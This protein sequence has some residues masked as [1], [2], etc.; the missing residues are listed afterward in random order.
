MPTEIGLWVRR[1]VEA[2]KTNPRHSEMFITLGSVCVFSLEKNVAG[3][4]AQ[5]WKSHFVLCSSEMCLRSINIGCKNCPNTEVPQHSRFS[6]PFLVV[7]FLQKTTFFFS[8]FPDET[9]YNR[10]V[11]WTAKVCTQWNSFFCILL[12]F[13][14]ITGKLCLVLWYMY[15][16]TV[17]GP[18]YFQQLELGCCQSWK[19]QQGGDT[20][21][22]H[23]AVLPWESVLVAQGTCST[24]PFLP[25]QLHWFILCSGCSDL[26][27]ATMTRFSYFIIHLLVFSLYYA[28]CTLVL[29]FW[30]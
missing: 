12:L 28:V 18:M 19:G 23:L 5:R 16:K 11:I 15:V 1:K 9:K 22:S 21:M 17:A 14:H 6:V 4:A 2:E 30:C 24:D 27:P 7:S 3:M 25:E 8:S 26:Q 13:I 10:G 20:K 29:L